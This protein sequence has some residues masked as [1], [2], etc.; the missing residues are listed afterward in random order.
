MDLPFLQSLK[1]NEFYIDFSQ[2]CIGLK[3]EQKRTETSFIVFVSA[4]LAGIGNENKNP[5]NEYESGNHRRRIRYENGH[6]SE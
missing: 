6:L 1:Y 3:T 4:C 2:S 5:E